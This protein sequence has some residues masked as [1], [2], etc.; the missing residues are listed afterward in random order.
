MDIGR[1]KNILASV[2][3]YEYLEGRV[4]QTVVNVLLCVS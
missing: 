4:V 1:S 2:T 3:V